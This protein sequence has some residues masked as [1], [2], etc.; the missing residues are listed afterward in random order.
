MLKGGYRLSAVMARGPVSNP[1][2]FHQNYAQI[3][4]AEKK[5]RGR[6]SGDSTTYNGY[7][8]NQHPPRG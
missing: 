3:R 1:A 7:I 6:Y 5:V 4:V 2:F 8:R